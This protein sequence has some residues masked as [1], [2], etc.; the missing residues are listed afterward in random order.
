MMA[1]LTEDGTDKLAAVSPGH[2]AEV[3]KTMFDLL[4]PRDVSVLGRVFEEMR[5]THADGRGAD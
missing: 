1:E 2:V 5:A 4:S 3:R